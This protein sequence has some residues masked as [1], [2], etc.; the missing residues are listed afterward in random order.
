[1]PL[2]WRYTICCFLIEF[3]INKSHLDTSEVQQNNTGTGY[4]QQKRNNGAKTSLGQLAELVQFRPEDH[5][6][7]EEREAGQC[8]DRVE[9][10][11]DD[12]HPSTDGD[13]EF[14]RKADERRRK[15]DELRD[16]RHSVRT[17]AAFDFTSE[18]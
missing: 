15:E 6:D 16:F 9:E 4:H 7:D 14:N 10:Q 1:M 18:L 2:C 13:A 17:E 11:E 3:K 5:A 8:E 12:G